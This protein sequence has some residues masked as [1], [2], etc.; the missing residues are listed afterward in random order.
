[1]PKSN[2]KK[3]I[4]TIIDPE[5]ENEL[6][7]E[8][9]HAQLKMLKQLNQRNPTRKSLAQYNYLEEVAKNRNETWKHVKSPRT[10]KKRISFGENK[11]KEFFKALPA[12]ISSKPPKLKRTHTVGG[13]RNTRKNRTRKHRK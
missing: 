6:D 4:G 10:E 9:L 5:L 7:N 2:T 11:T 12:N 3:H 13:K 1:M 8:T